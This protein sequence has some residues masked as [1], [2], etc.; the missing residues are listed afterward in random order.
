MSNTAYQEVDTVEMAEEQQPDFAAPIPAPAMD[1]P[2]S[3][4]SV[5]SAN[6]QLKAR[7]VPR[8]S[9]QAFCEDP[10]TAETAQVAASDRRLAKT[11]FSVHM[12]GIAA[13]ISH[14]QE[15][16]TPNLVIIESMLDRDGMLND[17][18]RLA[19]VCDAGTRVVLIGHLNDVILYRELVSRGVSEYLIAPI[20]PLQ[21]MQSISN[22]YNDPEAEPVGHVTAYVGAKG[23]V[24]SSTVCHN[25]AWTV[26]R[27]L[28]SD[29]VIADMDLPFG[30]AG[31]DFNQD[32]VQGIADALSS[33]E[34]L[35]E[36][37]LDRLL[38]KCSDN[39]AL[40]AAPGTLD[41]EYDL[42]APT[43]ESVI[44]IVRHNVPHVAI[45]VPHLWTEW[46]RNILMQADE[47][48][49]TATP[50]L[51][52]LRNAKNMIDLM[53]QERQND[54]PPHLIINMANMPKRPEIP[55][56]DFAGA[57]ELTPA[58][59]IDFN[60]E[61]FGTASNN[62]QMVEELDKQSQASE[63]FNHLAHVLTNRPEVVKEEKK[64]GL[65]FFKRLKK[66]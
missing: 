23:G 40:F 47:V 49:I 4:P 62:G 59:I 34:R 25:T 29:V 66:K 55:L 36:V 42:E 44:D 51:A 13:A 65:S 22:I 2:A 60:P 32:P 26:S 14:Y 7:P 20:A 35:D 46:A 27:L 24:G 45:D 52:N 8:I 17:L 21:V 63:A 11:H 31:L 12:G 43:C 48:V 5:V 39:L 18:D 1:V 19:E 61:L 56:K 6:D 58:C 15:A 50:D 38:S 41:R 30:T 54:R 10:R 53:R 9:I 16:P 33:P 57:L 3:E 28:Q 64:S 37:L